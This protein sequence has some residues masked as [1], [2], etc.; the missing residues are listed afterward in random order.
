MPPYYYANATGE[1]KLSGAKGNFA[2]E[3]MVFVV[4]SA[5]GYLVGWASGRR[6]RKLSGV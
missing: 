2:F 4:L 1:G 3:L 6:R 5:V